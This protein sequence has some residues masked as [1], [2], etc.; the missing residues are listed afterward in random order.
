MWITN[1]YRKE[2]LILCCCLV[3]YAF[4]S[5]P[6]PTL[7]SAS[8][9]PVGVAIGY[10]PMIRDSMYRQIVTHQFDQVSFEY[11][12]KNGAIVRPDGQLDFHQADTLVQICAHA[13]LHIYGHTLC[14]YQNNSPYM[15]RLAGDSAAIEAFLKQYIFTVM[16][17]YP[18]I[19]AWDVV[20]EAIDDSTGQLRVDGPHRP[21]Y[22]YWGKY[23]GPHYVE[24]VFQYAHEA[25]PRAELFY[26]DYDLE[27]NPK[28]L[29][30]VLELIHTLRMHHIPIT[31]IGTQMHISISTPD[32][33]VDRMFQALAATGLQ[34]R[35]SE[36]DIRV[37]PHHDPHAVLTPELERLQAHKAADVIRSYFRNIP[38]AQ[39]H[40]ITFW[41]VGDRDSWIVR[42]LH[43]TDWPTMF[44]TAYHPKP[45]FDSVYQV[46]QRMKT[47]RAGKQHSP[48]GSAAY[49]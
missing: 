16:H 38:P 24:R 42:A 21:G 5:F 31:G 47:L 1:I 13:G 45:M 18:Q 2:I 19:R 34:V 9:I 17:R 23:L 20:N 44:D 12:L 37:N 8:P 48:A 11:A 22:F 6:L 40:D 10:M 33:G 14:W 30:G 7:K 36:L 46:L 25:N 43:E 26:N 27:S 4:G 3:L 28:K 32:S 39:R 41:N 49:P 15:Q 29:Q 35:I